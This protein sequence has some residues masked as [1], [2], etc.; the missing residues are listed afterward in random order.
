MRALRAIFFF[1]VSLSALCCSRSA[2]KN[3]LYQVGVSVA[4]ITPKTGM[5]I[6]GG[7]NNRQ[8]TGIHDSLYVKAV[9][10]SD[11]HNSVA[12]LTFDCIGLLYPTLLK[13]R[14]VVAKQVPE[15]DFDPKHI[16]MASTHT[17][18]GPDV[19]GIWGPNPLISGVDTV[20]M[21]DLVSKAAH[22][23]VEALHNRQPATAAF[24][25][26][27]FGEG[28]VYNISDSLSLDRSL[29]AIQ[30]KGTN[31]KSIATL[32]NFACHPTILDVSANDQVSADYVHG[33]Y[34]RLDEAWGG[35]NLFLQGSIGGW[36]QPEYEKKEFA[37][38]EKRGR[39]LGDKVVSILQNGQ[40][41][42]NASVTFKRRSL[43]FP[44][45]NP[46][47]R[48]LAE[49]GVIKRPMGDSVAT[50]IVWFSIGN[51]QFATHPG[52]TTPVHSLET[53][54]LMQNKGPK[55]VIG[56]GMDALGYILSPNFF[57]PARPLHHTEYMMSMSIDEGAGPVLMRHIADISKQ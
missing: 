24:A 39:E 45:S 29:S 54:A 53:K 43:N 41:L 42:G 11:A 57:D 23:V 37:A 33:L 4:N 10:V 25:V 7:G 36:V 13:I 5:F 44:L 27:T 31:G 20:Y 18:S 16:V 28:W 35:A 49:A 51:A 1:A 14:E 32:T 30:F 48:Q 46:G 2:Q 15:A 50:E 52:E 9:V 21:N 19:V 8:F 55:I 6:A 17:H 38:A 26:S 34:T 12:I 47:F 56:L 3:D 40:T 22:T